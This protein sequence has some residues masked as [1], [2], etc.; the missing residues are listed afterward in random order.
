MYLPEPFEITDKDEIFSFIAKN[1]FGQM[2]SNLRR[3]PCCSHLPFLVSED[4]SR[5]MSHFARANPQWREIGE[6]QVLVTF[7][8]PHGYISPA[9][10]DQPGVPTWNYQAV[11][12]YG[13][14]ST[15]DQPGR[16]KGLLAKLV[17]KYEAAFE[18][19]WQPR[20]PDELLEAIVGVEIE[21]TEIQCKYKLSQNRSAGDR[22]RVIDALERQGLKS[23]AEAMNK[24]Q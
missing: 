24:Q 8:G 12:V 2:I 5:L 11:H 16:L 9:W 20:Y 7:Q 19:P 23:L 3:R 22:Q 4:R 10:Y 21:I 1:S 17:D 15:F 6:Q 14:C 13:E 18:E